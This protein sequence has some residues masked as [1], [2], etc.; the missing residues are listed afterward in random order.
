[1]LIMN[2]HSLSALEDEAQNISEQ[3]A[4]NCVAGYG[5]GLDLTAREVQKMIIEKG[6]PWAKSKGVRGAA[7]ISD[8]IST[9][10]II[11]PRSL[12]FSLN[13][14]GQTRQSD[15][16]S[17]MIFSIPKLISYLSHIYGLSTGDII[18]TGTPAGVATIYPGA[19]FGLNLHG[20][21]QS[22]I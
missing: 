20:S 17:N 8:F 7:C 10:I 22:T 18:Y 12:G 13:V 2:A 14:N 4:L 21:P 16:S 3:N 19:I 6:L 9:N 15:N 11:D 1:M 5:I